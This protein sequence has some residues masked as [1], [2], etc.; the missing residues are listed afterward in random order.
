MISNN[1]LLLVVPGSVGSKLENLSSKV[2]EDGGEEWR[3][4]TLLLVAITSKLKDLSS[5]VFEDN[6]EVN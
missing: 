2:F 5:K 4:N 1:T 6:G 3:N